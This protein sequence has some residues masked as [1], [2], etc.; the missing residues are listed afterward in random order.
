MFR[1]SRNSGYLRHYPNHVSPNEHEKSAENE[2]AIN[3]HR[4]HFLSEPTMH[5]QK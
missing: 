4:D 1:L 3:R 5:Q 2:V